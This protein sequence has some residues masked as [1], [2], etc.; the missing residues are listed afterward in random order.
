M[1]EHRPDPIPV[2]DERKTTEAAAYLLQR[3]GGEMYFIKLL[4]LLYI[5][6]RNSILQWK[7]PITHDQY[8]SMDKGPVLSRTYQIINET[9]DESTS[10][11]QQISE[12]FDHKVRLNHPDRHIDPDWL[13]ESELDILDEVFNEFGHWDR[14]DLCN[15]THGFPEW[16]DPQGSMIPFTIRD[17]QIGAGQSEVEIDSALELIAVHSYLRGLEKRA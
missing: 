6:D 12:R 5:A 4:K 3:A 7:E 2:F 1:D 9:Y 10:W 16:Q 14:F 8:V 15:Y 17:I 13:S 11:K